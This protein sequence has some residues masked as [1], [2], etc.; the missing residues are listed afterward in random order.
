MK[1]VF[2]KNNKFVDYKIDDIKG[3]K[4]KPRKKN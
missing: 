2:K 4:F 3:Y 1:V